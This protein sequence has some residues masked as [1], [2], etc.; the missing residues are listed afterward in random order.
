[1][2]SAAASAVLGATGDST[3]ILSLS[4][5]YEHSLARQVMKV[6]HPQGWE[7]EDVDDVVVHVVL[8]LD[9]IVGDV[10]TLFFDSPLASH[11]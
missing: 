10:F 6:C 4:A 2:A 8:M 5:V 7:F 1:M 9:V 11:S 3:V